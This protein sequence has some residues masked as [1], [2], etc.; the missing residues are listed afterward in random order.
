MIPVLR[1]SLLLGVPAKGWFRVMVNYGSSTL[2]PACQLPKQTASQ[3]Q[4][5]ITLR[6]VPDVWA[7][8]LPSLWCFMLTDIELNCVSLGS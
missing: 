6:L 5:N 4:L 8:M 1:L 3:K 7:V 2:I